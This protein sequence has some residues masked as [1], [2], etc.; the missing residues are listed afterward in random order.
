MA[1][2]QVLASGLVERVGIAGGKEASLKHRPAG[3]DEFFEQAEMPNH[4]VAMRYVLAA[5]TDPNHGVIGSLNEIKA[6]GHRVLHGGDRFQASVVIDDNVIAAIEDYVELG[7]LHNPAN[8]MGIRAC[9]A[10]LPSVPQIAVFDTAFHATM[11]RRAFLYGLPYE[12]YEKDRIRRY[13]FHGTSHRYVTLRATKLLEAR[14]VP[15]AE[16]KFI[17]V[18]IGNGCSMAAV[19]GG[20]CIDTSMGLTPLE[21]L[22]MGTRTGDIDPAAVTA[23]QDKHRLS[24]TEIDDLLN[25]QSGL[26]GVSGVSSDMRDVKAAALDG[27]ARAQ[28]AVEIFCYRIQKYIGAYA[29]AL[30]GI[31]A[32]V[33]TAGIGENDPTIRERSINELCFLGIQLDHS[34]NED[35]SLRGKEID[36]AM[37][38]SRVRVFVI[39]TDEELMIAQ[40]TA[41]LVAGAEG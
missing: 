28:A 32:V 9:Q 35:N 37:P 38:E 26:L 41:V 10:A 25:K 2:Q 1:N 40:D 16:Q 34:K 5:L 24:R 17:T 23:I 39:P 33:F 22:L 3:D 8:L 7:P 30:G 4:E 6:V 20:K 12:F 15:A 13:G 29:A 19:K 31:D 27:N 36:I 11:P 21:G 18:H 14:G